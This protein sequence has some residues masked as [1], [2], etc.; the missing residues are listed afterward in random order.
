MRPLL[1]AVLL[2]LP[3]LSGCERGPDQDRVR[4]ELQQ[5]L[6]SNFADGLFVVESLHRAGSAPFKDLERGISGVFVYYDAELKFQKDYS[7]TAWRGLNIGTLAFA[8]GATEAGIQGFRSRGNTRGDLLRVHGRFAYQQDEQQAWVAIEQADEDHTDMAAMQDRVSEGRSPESV[9]ADARKLLQSASAVAD[10]TRKSLIVEELGY[11]V[12][13]IDLRNARL[14]GSILLT[15]GPV[16]GTYEGFGEA[17]SQYALERR[18]PLYSAASRGSVDNAVRLQQALVDFALMQSDVAQLLYQGFV[19]EGLAPL[20]QLR[21]VASLWPEAV[22]LLTLR[23]SGITRLEDLRGRRIAIGER[24]S[25]SRVNARVI[26]RAAAMQVGDFAVLKELPLP[27]AI[28]ALEAGDI[29]ALFL[30]EA[31]P[32]VAVQAL[33]VRRDDLRFVSL[34]ASLLKQLAADNFSYYPLKIVARTYPGQLETFDTLG[35]AAALVTNAS[36][37][38]EQVDI[39]LDLLMTGGDAL[40]SNYYRA[41]FISRETMRLGLALPL[42]PAAE[43]Y[44]DEYDSNKALPAAANE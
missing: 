41:A 26:G 31:V 43:R 20:P 17:L 35:L 32:S 12:T 44:Y 16:G 36:V 24:G 21:A 13:Q 18:V 30:T 19:Q 37:A 10:D 14:D 33:A 28:L 9:L 27:V 22:H 7:L 3:V 25:G 8:I 23:G 11:A 15:S 38:D 1:L 40:A 29:D 2:L 42:H 34:P 4:Q 6:D 5:R 39:I